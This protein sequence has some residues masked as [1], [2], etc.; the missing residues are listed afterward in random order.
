MTVPA[1]EEKIA[2]MLDDGPEPDCAVQS[3]FS[4]LRNLSDFPFPGRST[5]DEKQAVEDRVRATVERLGLF[6]GGHYI[7]LHNGDPLEARYRAEQALVSLDVLQASGPRGAYI[8]A[9]C[10]MSLSINGA[11]HLCI[12]GLAS[13]FQ[14]YD[15]WMRLNQIDDALASQLNLAHSKQFGYLTSALN[16]CGTGVRATA[17]VCLPCLTMEG[18]VSTLAQYMRQR[19]HAL[20]GVR[21]CVVR[22]APPAM[23]RGGSAPHRDAPSA[24]EGLHRSMSDAVVTDVA[25]AVGD[26]YLLSHTTTLGPSEPEMAFCM[27][28]VLKEI[29]GR[30]RAAR[31]ALRDTTPVRLVDRAMRALGVAQN[32][33]LLGYGEGLELLASLRLGHAAGVLK[34]YTYSDLNTLIMTTQSTHL[35]K[36]LGGDVDDLALN[37][38]RAAMFR[39]QFSG[40]VELNG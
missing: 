4:L 37:Q 15:V 9:D 25:E 29:L 33:R 32:A 7:S 38:E 11:D 36:K 40:A 10:S 26:L 13:G 18:K 31:E 28:H 3:Q 21:P 22:V 17:L 6:E 20:R 2:W 16:Q 8:S 12:T 5:G 30:E 35:E 34:G 27:R 19:R 14:M 39:E 1:H 23:K 24:M